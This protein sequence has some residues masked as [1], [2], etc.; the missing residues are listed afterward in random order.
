MPAAHGPHISEHRVLKT[1][2]SKNTF[3][4][5]ITF[6]HPRRTQSQSR[7]EELTNTADPR[8]WKF[9][10]HK[11]ATMADAKQQIMDQLRQQAALSNMRAL[12]DV[13][14]GFPFTHID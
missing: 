10:H 12:I 9:R 8:I 3:T 2:Q 11:L 5:H 7:I 13:R 4:D 6:I 1:H 14:H